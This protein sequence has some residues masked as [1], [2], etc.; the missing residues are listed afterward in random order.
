MEAPEFI[1][2]AGEAVVGAT[3]ER[4][5]VFNRPENRRGRVL[6]LGGA[7][8]KPSVV[9]QVE[10]KISV[11]L[12]VVADEMR[13]RVFKT[14]EDAG[15]EAE[16][17]QMEGNGFGSTAET[18]F[19]HGRQVFKEREPLDERDEFS[20][21]YE[22]T[23]AVVPGEFTAWIDGEG[24]V[25]EINLVCVGVEGGSGNGIVGPENSPSIVVGEEIP[26]RIRRVGVVAKHGWDCGFGPD[27][28][29]RSGFKGEF[30]KLDQLIESVA[31][32]FRVKNEVLGNA[33]LNQGGFDGASTSRG[34]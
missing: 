7:F 17:A 14:D 20:K 31:V 22:E 1:D 16:F 24:A 27:K 25:V 23:F 10:E 5:A 28:E 29:L 19:A 6:P 13:E 32:L 33:G 30:R 2:P 11:L 21:N 8:A 3:D 18:V 34:W 4:G 26:N 15:G 12:D 9:G